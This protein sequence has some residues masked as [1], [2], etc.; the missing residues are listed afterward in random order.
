MQLYASRPD[1]ALA[2]PAR[3]LAGFTAVEAE[4]GEAVEVDVE[5]GPRALAHWDVAAGSFA[6]EP[7]TFVL[8][9][10]RSSADLRLSARLTTG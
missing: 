4:P 10:G 3:W 8:A 9:A 7:G 5:L 1:S 6:V 2:R